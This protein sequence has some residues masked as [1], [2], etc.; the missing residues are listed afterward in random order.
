MK[1]L[2]GI[3]ALEDEV[4]WSVWTEVERVR[5]NGRMCCSFLHS[6]HLRDEGHFRGLSGMDLFR[7]AFFLPCLSDRIELVA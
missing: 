5:C 2:D 3:I 1:T 7:W 4:D 6:L